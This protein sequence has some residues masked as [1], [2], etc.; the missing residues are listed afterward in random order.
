MRFWLLVLAAT[1]L[2]G[3]ASFAAQ[4]R[5]SKL[6]TLTR[7]Y[8]RAI[9]WSDFEAAL[10]ATTRSEGTSRPETSSFKYIKVTSYAPVSSRAADDG[11]SFKRVVRISYV[12]TSSMIERSVTTE[13]EWEY[14]D[15]SEQWFLRSG[16]P[17]FR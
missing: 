17:Q 16:F 7:A 11:R 6:D 5:M 2:T 9:E 14:S 1:V 13:E 8:E 4:H 12:H 3:C 15:Q 10:A